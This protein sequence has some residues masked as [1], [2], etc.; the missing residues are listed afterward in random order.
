MSNF[1]PEKVVLRGSSITFFHLK[2]KAA[3]SYRLLVETY[4]EHAPTQSTCERWFVRFRNGDFDLE[5]KERPSQPKKFED[6]E[7]Q[8]LFK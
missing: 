5:D 2:K 1:V 7:L 8:A 3:E 6:G 4:G